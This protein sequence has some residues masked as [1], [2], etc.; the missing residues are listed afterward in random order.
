[1][2]HLTGGFSDYI[3]L[4]SDK[5]DYN[6]IFKQMLEYRKHKHLLACSTARNVCINFN[7]VIMKLIITIQN[8]GRTR[9]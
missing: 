6:E 1:M 4:R 2:E 7:L 9:F 3:N 5:T 8:I